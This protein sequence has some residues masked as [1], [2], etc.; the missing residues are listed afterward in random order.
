MADRLSHLSDDAVRSLLDALRE[1]RERLSR[2][3][4]GG[5]LTEY[6]RYMILSRRAAVELEL[7]RLTAELARRVGEVVRVGA[8]ASA[9][10]VAELVRA[11]IRVDPDVVSFAQET[12]AD[13][14]RNVADDV[15]RGVRRAVVRALAG[16]LNREGLDLEIERALGAEN[17]RG[18]VE[19][20]ARTELSRSYAQQGVAANRELLARGSDLIQ[21]WVSTRD[22]RTRPEHAAIHGQERELDQPFHIGGGATAATAPDAGVGFPANAP[23]DPALPPELGIQCRCRRVLVPRSEAQQPYIRRSEAPEPG[24]TVRIPR[25]AQ[26]ATPDRA[27]RGP[28]SAPSERELVRILEGVKRARERIIRLRTVGADTSRG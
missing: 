5:R 22:H 12:A 13:Q 3:L 8:E 20:I 23:L 24:D 18:R 14:V 11:P 15:R 7:D 9:R 27:S 1:S 2:D 16:G 17:T 10:D 6:G 21:R 28:Q 4:R 26:P 19:R 25:A